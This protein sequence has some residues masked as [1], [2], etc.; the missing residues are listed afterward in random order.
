R[1]VLSRECGAAHSSSCPYLTAIDWFWSRASGR[2]TGEKELRGCGGL[3][4]S[5]SKKKR[6]GKKGEKK[7]TDSSRQD[8]GDHSSSDLNVGLERQLE[9]FEQQVG[10]E[11][12]ADLN[13][14][15][16]RN[17]KS[18]IEEHERHVELQS[19]HE[20]Q[21]TDLTKRFQAEEEIL[22]AKLQQLTAELQEY[23]EL[24][25]RVE[26]SVFKKDLERNI[27]QHGSLARLA[28]TKNREDTATSN[29]F[30]PFRGVY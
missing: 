4:C 17:S 8:E 26:D 5:H 21:K 20:Q 15:Q 14:L 30:K 7:Q 9:S 28:A 6:K 18:A 16:G 25:T 22:K 12:T 10:T 23:N 29:L 27:Q 13:V 24:K 1:G 2:S 11:T 3:G 19:K